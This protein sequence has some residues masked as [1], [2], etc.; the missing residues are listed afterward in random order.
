MSVGT[1]FFKVYNRVSAPTRGFSKKLWYGFYFKNLL[2]CRKNSELL[3]K[4][5]IDV[6]FNSSTEPLVSVIIPTYNRSRLLIERAIPS[7]LAQS[8]KNF[9]L[10]VV[11]DHCTDD[12][13]QL[14]K[15]LDD[16]RVKFVNLPVGGKY[17]KKGYNR[18]LVAGCIPRN[19]GL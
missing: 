2:E 4:A 18:W 16:N 15:K 7:V 8:Y 19:K 11:G 13:E 3:E 17:P 14:V 9:E 12:T 5:R 10:I 6:K 1:W